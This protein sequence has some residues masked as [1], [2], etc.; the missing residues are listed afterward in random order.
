VLQTAVW[1][2]KESA[3]RKHKLDIAQCYIVNNYRSCPGRNNKSVEERLSRKKEVRKMSFLLSE[4]RVIFS[5]YSHLI[6]SV[7]MLYIEIYFVQSKVLY[8]IRHLFYSLNRWW[9]GINK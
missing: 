1:K 7:F 9:C 8:N 4:S 3:S 2:M 6:L 5:V